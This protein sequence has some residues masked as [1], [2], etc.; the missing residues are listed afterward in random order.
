[1][2]RIILTVFSLFAFSQLALSSG[3]EHHKEHRHHGAHEHSKG[4]M[5]LALEGHKLVVEIKA[6]S[7]DIVGFGHTPSTA[8]DKAKVE[9]AIM[10]L[11]RSD[12]IMNL[13]EG[14]HCK[15]VGEVTVDAS[16]LDKKKKKEVH[17][18][19]KTTYTFE[20]S[21]PEKLD[22]LEVLMFDRFPTL[23]VLA[24]QAI[25]DKGQFSQEVTTKNRVLKLRK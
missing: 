4:K 21:N 10:T 3:H 9:L 13:P 1:M 18:H 15:D 14:A 20:C 17:S 24:T 2:R 12:K 11:K 25:T 7:F 16:M 22:S 23:K 19:F 6:T 5:T 8:A